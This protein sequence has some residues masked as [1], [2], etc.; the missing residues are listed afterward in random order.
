MQKK[1]SYARFP[2]YKID[3]PAEGVLH[4][5][6]NRPRSLNAVNTETWRQ[7]KGIFDQA[8]LDK[9][10]NVIVLSGQGRSF[11]A[12]LDVKALGNDFTN[13]E[14]E[15]TSR[16]AINQYK[17]IREFQDAISR[18]YTINKP[19]IAAIHGICLGLG[20]DIASACDFRYAA[21]D[22]LFSIREVDIG[23]AADMGTLQRL[24]KL[25]N[26]LGWLKEA[27]YTSRNFKTDE[28]EKQ[29]LIDR[30]FENQQMLLE[31]ALEVAKS[32]AEKSPVAVQGTKKTIN[33]ALDHNH[34]DS[35]EQIAEYNAHAVGNDLMM[36]AAAAMSKKKP[37][38]A[39][40]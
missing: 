37:K 17:Y 26:N 24:P 33:Y 39:K 20:I 25:V 1:L 22:T 38:Y 8:E 36:G 14:N 29:G 34:A 5:S 18:P 15:D 30:T 11:C 2:L 3:R 27:S 31:N 28:A 23:M 32:I 9:D 16:F 19:V 12:G 21:K 6:F 4:V 7:F 13:F 10:V 35:L 40:L